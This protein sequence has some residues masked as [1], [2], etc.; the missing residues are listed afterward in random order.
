MKRKISLVAALL[1]L[2]SVWTVGLTS[3]NAGGPPPALEDVYDRVVRVIEASHEVNVLMFGSGLPVYPRGDKED[4][5][6]HRYYG[7]NDDGH[8]F[9]KPYAKFGSIPEMKQAISAVY[10]V[11]YRESLF[12]TLFTGYADED[13]SVAMPARFYENDKYLFQNQ[14]V[15]SLV[16]GIRLYD[17]STMQI[18]KGS[19]SRYL[20]ISV[21]SCTEDKPDEWVTVNLSF[22][23]ENGDWYLDS[24]SC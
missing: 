23:Y 24:P 10:S 17:Y 1:I 14:H 15:D 19:N 3:C 12:E 5:L 7:V 11:E 22:V 21:S 8:E 20:R 18:L 2:C 16:K 6:I 13:L 9:V 4:E